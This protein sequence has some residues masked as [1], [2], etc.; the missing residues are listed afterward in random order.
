MSRKMSSANHTHWQDTYYLQ[1]PP[2]DERQRG[3]RAQHERAAQASKDVGNESKTGAGWG[4]ELTRAMAY[5][6]KQWLATSLQPHQG[7]EDHDEQCWNDHDRGSDYGRERAGVFRRAHGMPGILVSIVVIHVPSNTETQ[8]G[9]EHAEAEYLSMNT[10]V[11]PVRLASS[12]DRE[13]GLRS[14]YIRVGEFE[15]AE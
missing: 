5:G 7:L 13:L 12:S 9:L 6:G 1:P 10:E 4:S 2:E 8:S 11:I 3:C 14:T 15:L